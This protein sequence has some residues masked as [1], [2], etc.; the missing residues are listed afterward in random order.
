M[1]CIDRHV[2]GRLRVWSRRIEEEFCGGSIVEAF[3]PGSIVVGN[4][5]MEECAALGVGV[6]LVLALVPDRRGP[7]GDGFGEAAV[8]ALDEAVGLRPEGS[9]QPVLDAVAGAHRSK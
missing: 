1:F 2:D 3:E 5:G 8:E 6:E 4:E 9:D 7:S